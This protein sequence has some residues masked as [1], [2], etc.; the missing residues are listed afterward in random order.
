MADSLTAPEL[1]KSFTD[2]ILRLREEE[3]ALKSD[4]RDVYAEAKANGLDKTILGKVVARL[5]AEAK[6]GDKLAETEEMVELYLS[7]YRSPSR[8]HTHVHAR[9]RAAEPAPGPA[10]EAN[11]PMAREVEEPA[12]PPAPAAEAAAA[13]EPPTHVE[14]AADTPVAPAAAVTAA[15]TADQFTPPAFLTGE[16]K[17]IRPNCLNPGNCAGYGSNHCHTCK[18]AAEAKEAA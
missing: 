2:R 10:T 5:R 17:S 8:A 11:D 7:A 9:A 14:A 16:R 1:V 4:I 3:D 18:K 12:A 15:P 6:D 13:P